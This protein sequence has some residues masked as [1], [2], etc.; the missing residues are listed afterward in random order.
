VRVMALRVVR[1]G[2]GH[3]SSPTAARCRGVRRGLVDLGLTR[4][5]CVGPWLVSPGFAWFL[6]ARPRPA[7]VIGVPLAWGLVA[8]RGIS[9]GTRPGIAT[10]RWGVWGLHAGHRPILARTCKSAEPSVQSA[11][12]DASVKEPLHTRELGAPG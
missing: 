10:G 9:A 1:Y 6:S 3:T 12:E 2:T 4:L 8:G 5:G 7:D 11:R